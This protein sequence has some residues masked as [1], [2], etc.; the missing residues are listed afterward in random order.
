[1]QFVL[2][3]TGMAL[4]ATGVLFFIL[5]VLQMKDNWRAGVQREEY[6]LYKKK[7]L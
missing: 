5:S 6:Y 1:M 3:I 2:G 4:T 7:V